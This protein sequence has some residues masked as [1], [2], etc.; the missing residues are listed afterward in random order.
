MYRHWCRGAAVQFTYHRR[1][2]PRRL[3]EL[4]ALTGLSMSHI[5]IIYT[6]IGFANSTLL[7]LASARNL[8]VNPF[9]LNRS[10]ERER[11]YLFLSR[12]NNTL[13]N[14]FIPV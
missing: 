4:K 1:G 14:K 10:L 2:K 12:V 13:F 3:R 7:K 8:L 9:L 6:A 5:K 11:I